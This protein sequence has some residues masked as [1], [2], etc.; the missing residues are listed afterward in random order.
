MKELVIKSIVY[1]LEGRIIWILLKWKFRR[2]KRFII[3]P[4][5]KLDY[6]VWGMVML[7]S[8]LKKEN[9]LGAVIIACNRKMEK[10]I[11]FMEL[12][13]IRYQ[14]LS[15]ESIN[16]MMKYYALQDRSREWTV[17]SLTNPYDTGAERLLGKKGITY[18]ELVYYDIYKFSNLNIENEI[19]EGL[20]KVKKIEII[21]GG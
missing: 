18:R 8:Y 16:K 11:Q 15:E 17:V 10:V 19:G 6:S 1:A 2:Y 9:L 21:L 13:N 12:D 7:P 5:D 14:A 20:Q 4:K 3:F